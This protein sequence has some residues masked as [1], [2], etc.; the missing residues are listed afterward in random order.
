MGAAPGTA[1]GPPSLALLVGCSLG[2]GLGL[3]GHMSSCLGK[4]VGAGQLEE[5]KTTQAQDTGRGLVSHT[6]P[7]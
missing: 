2:W 3:C 5:E 7:Y 1:L 6:H 4:C